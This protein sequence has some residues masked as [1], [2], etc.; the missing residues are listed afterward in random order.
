MRNNP[1]DE[2]L[3]KIEKFLELEPG[4]IE[5]GRKLGKEICENSAELKGLILKKESKK[6]YM[7]IVSQIKTRS[8]KLAADTLNSKKGPLNSDWKQLA[9]QD[10]S[11]LK[12]EILRLQEFLSVRENLLR[13]RA[14]EK[15]HGIDIRNLARRLRREKSIDQVLRS[16][17]TKLIENMDEEDLQKKVKEC[18][19][20][21]N[22]ISKWLLFLKEVKNVEG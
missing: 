18:R 3:E 14:N 22:R 13:K 2:I 11:K 10:Q 20:R 9:K 19:E 15:L 16:Q 8:T 7:K 5:E 17:L 6:D 12:D 4:E 1:V 21:L